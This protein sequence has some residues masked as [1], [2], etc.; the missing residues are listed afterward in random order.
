[1]LIIMTR[2]LLAS[3]LLG[4]V[5]NSYALRFELPIGEDNIVGDITTAEIMSPADNL[6]KIGRD[7]D[8]GY[9]AMREANPQLDH[10]VLKVGDTV[11]IPGRFVLPEVPREGIVVNLA[12]MRLYY[13]PTGA[14]EVYTFPIGI[15]RV[16]WQSPEGKGKIIQKTKDPT[17]HVPKSIW[18]ARAKEGVILP[19]VVK[20]G[21]DNPLGRYRMRLSFPGFL[22]HSTNM[23]E[24]VGMRSSS[25]CL[26]MLPADAEQLFTMVKVG[27]PV[28]IINRPYKAGWSSQQFYL[29]AHSPLQELD[30]KVSDLNLTPMVM[31]ISAQLHGQT[32]KVNWIQAR[33]VAEEELGIPEIIGNKSI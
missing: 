28:T 29:E 30:D 13:F 15:G 26:R 7:H 23:P 22:I 4:M 6:G 24:G 11:V 21:P 12:E 31:A 33:A 27:T 9:F 5:L 1:M 32:V 14:K 8:I 2:T 10:E 25:G 20:P 19:K 17:W 18:E 3:F 16:A